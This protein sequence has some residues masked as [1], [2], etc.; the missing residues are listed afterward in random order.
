ML[1]EALSEIQ[2]NEGNWQKSYRLTEATILLLQFRSNDFLLSD[3]FK[4]RTIWMY[5]T[6]NL[7]SF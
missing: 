6:N 2:G 7:V 5:Y 1:P 3:L 4:I